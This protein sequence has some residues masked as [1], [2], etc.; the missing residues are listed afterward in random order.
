MGL[1]CIQIFAQQCEK[2]LQPTVPLAWPELLYGALFTLNSFTVIMYAKFTIHRCRYW[3]SRNRDSSRKA[4]NP[5]AG[6]ALEQPKR[7]H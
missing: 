7:H 3:P 2:F 6:D 4:L 1:I 5:R